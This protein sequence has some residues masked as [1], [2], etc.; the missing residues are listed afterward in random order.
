MK[1]LILKLDELKVESYPT[2]RQSGPKGT[3][4]GHYGTTHTEWGQETCDL[5][6]MQSCNGGWSCTC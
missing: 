5:S 6:C 4:V 3:V 2:D 1:K